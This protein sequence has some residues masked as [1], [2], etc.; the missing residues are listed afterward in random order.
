[1]YNETYSG[2][3]KHTGGKWGIVWKQTEIKRKFVNKLGLFPCTFGV[4]TSQWLQQEKIPYSQFDP[5]LSVKVL[6]INL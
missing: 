1:M 5:N 3:G 2:K 4:S 6:N